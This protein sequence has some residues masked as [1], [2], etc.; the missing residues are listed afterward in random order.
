MR[1]KIYYERPRKVVKLSLEQ[2]KYIDS[3]YPIRKSKFISFIDPALREKD[4]DLARKGVLNDLEIQ[5]YL[6][7][8]FE[9]EYLGTFDYQNG[10]Y[11]DYYEDDSFFIAVIYKEEDEEYYARA[12]FVNNKAKLVN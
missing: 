6:D 7:F 10:E 4:V 5:T 11:I 3:N 2:A 8:A 1:K 12:V 9:M